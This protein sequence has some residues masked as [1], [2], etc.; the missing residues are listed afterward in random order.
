[1]GSEFIAQPLISGHRRRYLPRPPG[2]DEVVDASFSFAVAH[3]ARSAHREGD[4]MANLDFPF[5]DGSA[6]LAETLLPHLEPMHRL[7]LRLTGSR[8]DAE[9]L[10]AEVLHRLH[11]HRHRL[12]GIKDLRT[13][14]FRVTYHQFVRQTAL[15]PRPGPELCALRLQLKDYLHAALDRIA[16]RA[17][18][19][20]A[21]SL[22]EIDGLALPEIARRFQVSV[23]A[24]K[25]ALTEAR[26]ALRAELS[27]TELLNARLP[28]RRVGAARRIERPVLSRR[29]HRRRPWPGDDGSHLTPHDPPQKDRG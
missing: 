29:R 19:S 28:A 9:E 18:R 24:L 27:A 4:S 21:P 10:L 14:L 2:T 11:V 16:P 12:R 8:M 3:P 17:A 25:A 26:A 7:A 15:E 6:R 5:L 22:E 20:P 13:W 23:P 1:M